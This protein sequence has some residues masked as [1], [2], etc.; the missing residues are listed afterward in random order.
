MLSCKEI[1]QLT[2]DYVDKELGF[3]KRMQ[4][5]LHLFMCKNCQRFVEQFETTV[6][7]AAKLNPT[8]PSDDSLEKQVSSLLK[9]HQTENKKR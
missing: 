4:F 6:S 8:T 7:V 3:L 1:T 5:R 9:L 2:S